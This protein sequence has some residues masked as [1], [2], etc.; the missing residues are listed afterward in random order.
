MIDTL[1]RQIDQLREDLKS[2]DLEQE[3]LLRR[4]HEEDR[5]REL[6]DK[7]D[8]IKLQHDVEYVKKQKLEL[9]SALRTDI[10]KWRG[11]AEAAERKL[12]SSQDELKQCQNKLQ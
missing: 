2:K 9:E 8:N 7:N 11:D 5:Q 3:T 1:N 10:Q 4:K 12:R 6:Q